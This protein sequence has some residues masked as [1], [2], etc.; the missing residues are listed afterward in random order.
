LCNRFDA[1][2]DD[3]V[4]AGTIGISVYSGGY[5]RVCVDG[6]A[7][8][9]SAFKTWLSSNNLQVVYELATPQAYQLTPQQ[10]QTLLGTNNV[11]ANSGDV[12]VIYIADT[13][14]YI[15]NH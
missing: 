11:W 3:Q 14:L 12:E 1:K 15:D 4:S 6:Q 7:T 2:T 9:V 5:I 10:I 13:K 8:T